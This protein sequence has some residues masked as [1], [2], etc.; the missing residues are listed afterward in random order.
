MRNDFPKF[1]LIRVIRDRKCSQNI[2]VMQET[3]GLKPLGP[4]ILCG[5]LE[6]T[7]RSA[8]VSAGTIRPRADRSL[9]QLLLN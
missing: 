3:W 1:K 4:L 5:D 9:F 6:L 2:Q 8:V 7:D